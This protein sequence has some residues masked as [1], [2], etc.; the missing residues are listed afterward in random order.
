MC[1]S[2]QAQPVAF[3]EVQATFGISAVTFEE[4]EDLCPDSTLLQAIGDALPEFQWFPTPILDNNLE[5]N[6]CVK[7]CGIVTCDSGTMQRAANEFCVAKQYGIATTHGW[8]D[9]A[10]D[11]PSDLN[12]LTLDVASAKEVVRLD[13]VKSIDL[14]AKENR[15]FTGI[16]CMTPQDQQDS[17]AIHTRMAIRPR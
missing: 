6:S 14:L 15:V 2:T 17:D 4:P 3:D 5:I 9:K 10:R 8:K 13:I 1:F 7:E 11:E 12:R 16:C